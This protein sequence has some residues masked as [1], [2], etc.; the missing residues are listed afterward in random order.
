MT[1]MVFC[2]KGPPMKPV[3]GKCG[4]AATADVPRVGAEVIM[5]VA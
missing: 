5:Y 3:S 2:F 1:I 4:A